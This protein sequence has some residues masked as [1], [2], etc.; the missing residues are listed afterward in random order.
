MTHDVIVLLS[1]LVM[2][3][4]TFIFARRLS[5]PIREFAAAAERL[6]RDP[7]VAPLPLLTSKF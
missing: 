4:I 2:A 3:P 5:A 1:A 6:G 7:G